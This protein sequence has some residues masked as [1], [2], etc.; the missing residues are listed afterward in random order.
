MNLKIL[1]LY[2]FLINQLSVK[3]FFVRIINFLFATWF[4]SAIWVFKT[5]P[6]VPMAFALVANL[7]NTV[8]LTTPLST[9]L[10]SLHKS[11]GPVPSY[12]YVFY[13]FQ[14]LRI[15]WRF[16]FAIVI[17]C[18]TPLLWVVYFI[19]FEFI[20]VFFSWMFFNSVNEI[21][22]LK[23]EIYRLWSKETFLI[24]LLNRLRKE[25][26]SLLKT[27]PQFCDNFWQLKVIYKWWKMH[28]I[29]P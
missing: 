28:F 26:S 15:Q 6:L 11:G 16:I 12:L 18:Y 25:I 13:L 20:P 1:A 5:N 8:F 27:H 10:R 19:Y 3:Y 4:I 9:T 24:Q 14:F 2:F 29:S 23:K 21:N 7:S 17:R 22:G